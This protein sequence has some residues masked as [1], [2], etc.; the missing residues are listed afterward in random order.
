MKKLLMIAN[1]ISRFPHEGGNGR[2][3][4]ILSLLD[5]NEWN[6]E[7]ITSNFSHGSKNHR[8]ITKNIQKKYPYKI[9]MLDEP[10]YK[11]NVSIRRLHSHRQL[12]K[13]L[14]KYLNTLNEKPE[15]I[16]CAIPSL[17]FA[18]A[19]AKY[20]KKNNIKFIIDVQDLW[21]EAFEMLIKI[22]LLTKIL[23]LPMRK[24]A[25]SIYR[26]ADEIIAVSKT[27]ANRAQKAN[28]KCRDTLSVFLG[29]DLS[30]FDK[31]ISKSKRSE[32]PFTIAYIGTLGH[33][34][35]IKC[36]IDAIDILQSKKNINDI[37]FLVMGDGPLRKDFESYAKS[38]KINARFTGKLPYHEMV[39]KLSMANLA[40]NP[41][42]KGAAQSIINK[43]GDYAAAGLPILNTEECEE[44]RKLI[45]KTKSGINV[46]NS[47]AEDLAKKIEDLYY[48]KDKRIKMGQNSRKTAEQYFDRATTYKRIIEAIKK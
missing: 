3:N 42:T 28:N 48:N 39:K 10:G 17:S 7:L 35:D 21:P 6:A 25:D 20:A 36:A 14:T 29:T 2:F 13:E 33:C 9:T 41:I 11:K 37:Y 40:I 22:P 12:S 31:Y 5:Y 24:K 23:F 32:Q 30:E 15:I 44:Y 4:Y 1:F 43:V 26:Q 16:Y 8:T 19:A 18:K 47:D 45:T 27:Y 34:Y 38:K 46:N